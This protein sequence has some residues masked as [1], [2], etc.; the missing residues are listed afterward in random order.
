MK[1]QLTLQQMIDER[2]KA[3]NKIKKHLSARKRKMR[4]A[5][6]RKYKKLTLQWHKWD[7][8]I[9]DKKKQ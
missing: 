7:G 3:A 1:K 4:L 6:N 8:L 2:K 9:K 5:W